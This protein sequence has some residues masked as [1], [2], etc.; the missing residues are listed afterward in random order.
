MARSFAKNVKIRG[1]F[2]LDDVDENIMIG[3]IIST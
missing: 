2:N 1:F 3:V